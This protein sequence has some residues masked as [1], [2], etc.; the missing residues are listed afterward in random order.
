MSI[1]KRLIH[2]CISY[3]FLLSYVIMLASVYNII[4]NYKKCKSV[5][6]GLL[7]VLLF[8]WLSP[9][10]VEFKKLFLVI[11]VFFSISTYFGEEMII[12]K[13]DDQAIQYFNCPKNRKAAPWLFTAYL[14]ML[15]N[16]LIIVQIYYKVILNKG[17]PFY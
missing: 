10:S 14:T 5:P 2:Y 13:T 15:I 9:Y 6:Y 12:Q 1:L 7:L 3:E 16:I 11:Y 8:L 4:R 17:L